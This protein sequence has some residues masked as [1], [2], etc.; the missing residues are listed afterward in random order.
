MLVLGQDTLPES[1]PEP[2]LKSDS[3]ARDG[4]VTRT[5]SSHKRG[6]KPVSFYELPIHIVREISGDP[7]ALVSSLLLIGFYIGQ[8]LLAPKKETV[9]PTGPSGS[10]AALE[11]KQDREEK[12]PKPEFK[13]SPKPAKSYE[14]VS[15]N[16]T[17]TKCDTVAA[18]LELASKQANMDTV[19]VVT[20]IHRS[21][22]LALQSKRTKALTQDE[23]FVSLVRQL[24]KMFDED[25]QAWT[26]TRAVG[27]TAWALAKLQYKDTDNK[28]SILDVL[29][30]N[31]SLYAE[32]FK[33]EELMNTV[34]A[35]AE[36]CREGKES[37]TA[38]AVA[39]ARAAARCA[40]EGVVSSCTTQQ[41]VYFAWAL[42]RLADINAVRSDPDVQKGFSTYKSL[43]VT[44]LTGQ[45]E[46]LTSKHLA[47]LSWAISH[48]QKFTS[49]P[50]EVEKLLQGIGQDVLRRGLPA[51]L[52]GE[53]ASILGAFSKVQLKDSPFQHAL[54]AHVVKDGCDGYTS[55]DLTTI[56]CGL[57]N[58]DYSDEAFYIRMADLV[59]RRAMDFNR[60]ERQML[61]R[62]FAR[63]Q[64]FR[65]KLGCLEN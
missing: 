17:L 18:V 44:G 50:E 47:M 41:Q 16:Q 38:R 32:K 43:L 42:A 19:N 56:I 36:L 60:L 3:L 37:S 34:W 9:T 29:H 28:I 27:N 23:R 4:P 11:K 24:H 58:L 35:F 61:K 15:F 33:P 5:Q 25:M 13:A 26:L 20:A 48:M 39:V 10:P 2:L 54:L 51:F 30:H 46:S 57:V 12:A 49:A 6:S 14:M 62:S 53:L 31:F 8:V 65:G 45:T 22:K 21:T 59:Q 64:G 55:Q 40:N 7:I 1:L 52:P 63:I